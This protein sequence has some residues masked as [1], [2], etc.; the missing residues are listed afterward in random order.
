VAKASLNVRRA[1]FL[2]LEMKN[3]A[4][5]PIGVASCS[6]HGG[7]AA[8]SIHLGRDRWNVTKTGL[9]FSKFEAFTSHAVMGS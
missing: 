3:L 5:A 8:I 6:R 4:A 9:Y 7:R 2:L 1:S